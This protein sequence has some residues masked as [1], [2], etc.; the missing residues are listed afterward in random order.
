MLAATTH[1]LDAP[2]SS[3]YRWTMLGA[4][5]FS[6][7]YWLSK[8]KRDPSLLLVYIGALGGAF[9]GA[10]L[11]Y[12]FAEG[13][14]DWPTEQRWL[15]L[16]SG[17]SVVGG[18]LGGYGGVELMKWL[19]QYRKSTGDLFAMIVP[20]GIA[21]GRVGC[22][23]QGCCLGKPTNISWLAIRDRQGVAR[24][25]AS[26]MELLFQLVMFGVLLLLKD[27]R[28]WLGR[29]FFFYLFCYGI[30]R[31]FH[32]FLRDTPEM[33]YGLSGYQW[34]SAL[35]AVIGAVMLWRR[36]PPPLNLVPA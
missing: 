11:A 29:L 19:L 34:L 16:A 35:M 12:L 23:L 1:W 22:W 8:S 9:L 3:P 31:F 21:L 17:K 5:A 15:R 33:F 2:L 7:W 24:W 20:L 36:R 6:A 30:F 32:E 26:Q 13:W 14:R 28:E 18:L 25:P 27:R 10:K 4:I